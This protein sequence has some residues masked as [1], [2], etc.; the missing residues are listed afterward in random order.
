MD[1]LVKALGADDG[2]SKSEISRI[3][4]DLDTE[5]GAFRDRSLGVGSL[6]PAAHQS[7]SLPAPEASSLSLR[8]PVTDK[9]LVPGPATMALPR[10]MSSTGIVAG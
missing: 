9:I 6:Q 8:I 2:I 7:S 10:S 1:D 3:C 4:A 5:A